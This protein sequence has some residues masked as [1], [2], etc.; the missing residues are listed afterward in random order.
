MAVDNIFSIDRIFL[1]NLIDTNVLNLFLSEFCLCDIAFNN[2]PGFAS[3]RDPQKFPSSYSYLV[4]SPL[5]L[6]VAS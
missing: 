6:Y 4:C 3:N 2:D 5:F 1:C